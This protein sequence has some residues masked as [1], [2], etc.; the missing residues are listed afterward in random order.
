MKWNSSENSVDIAKLNKSITYFRY[1]C[2]LLGDSIIIIQFS[3]WLQVEEIFFCKPIVFLISLCFDAI[4]DGHVPITG[5]DFFFK[6]LFC[7]SIPDFDLLPRI[8]GISPII[9]R[10]SEDNLLQSSF[11]FAIVSD[12]FFSSNTNS[13]RSCFVHENYMDDDCEH[14]S[15]I[16]ESGF[17][18]FLERYFL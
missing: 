4:T 17:E 7:H 10:L 2:T 9:F 16:Q 18:R 14:I 5:I 3:V 8:T 12:T 13:R 15:G 1:A 6:Y 11:L